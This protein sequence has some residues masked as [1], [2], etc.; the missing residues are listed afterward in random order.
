MALGDEAQIIPARG[1]Q[2]IELARVSGLCTPQQVGNRFARLREHD[3]LA[4]ITR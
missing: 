1:E 3:L 4:R 2:A